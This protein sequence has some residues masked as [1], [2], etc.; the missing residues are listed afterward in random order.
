MTGERGMSAP[1]SATAPAPATASAPALDGLIELQVNGAGGHDLTSEP[2]SVWAVGA[3]LARFGIEA[4][5]PTLV[6]PSWAI[7]DRARAAWAAGPPD[8][9]AGATP[10]GWHVEGPFIS[11]RRAGAHDPATLQAPDAR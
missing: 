10:L 8:G 6:S 1:A 2:E 9:Y 7:V 5:L 4:F 3:V 11:P